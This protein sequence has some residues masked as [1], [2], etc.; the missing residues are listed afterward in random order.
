MKHMEKL[1]LTVR[2]SIELLG[3]IGLGFILYAGR[4]VLTPIILAF[5]IAIMIYP[6]YRWLSGKKFPT[7]LAIGICLFVLIAVFAGITWFITSQFSVLI[8]DFPTIRKNVTLHLQ[9]LSEWINEKTDFSTERQLE[10][11]NEQGS[12]LLDSAGG[13]LTSA[14]SSLTGVVVLL[15]LLPIY[16]FLILYYK[17]LLLKFIFLWFPQESHGNIQEAMKEIQGITKSYLLGLVIQITYITILLG[18]ILAIIGI[19]HALLIGIMFGILN[20]IPYVGALIGNILG[21]VLTLSSSQELWHVIA[22]LGTIAVVQFLDNNIL[23]PRIVGSKVKLNAL[24]SIVAVF[25]G[26]AIG[27]VTGMFLSIP[28]MA[29]LKII[30]ERTPQFRQW[31]VLFG[32]EQP[33]RSPMAIPS[34]WKKRQKEG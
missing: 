5:F 1:P 13:L 8:T 30:F 12:K 22:V 18:G 14:A 19:K 16:I 24:A 20:L 33:E 11:I 17:N 15:G 10:I 25:V 6:L 29:V 34:F 23:M 9:N 28:M 21:V 7:W 3:L 26:G 4:G 31:A 32:D 27:G 2:R